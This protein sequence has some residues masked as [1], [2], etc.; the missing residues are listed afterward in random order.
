MGKSRAILS[1]MVSTFLVSC[2]L[3]GAGG[4]DAFKSDSTASESTLLDVHGAGAQ[5]SDPKT[6]DPSDYPEGHGP[7]GDVIRIYNYVR[8]VRSVSTT[9]DSYSIVD[10]GQT[11]FFD[12]RSSIAAPAAG[13][14]FYGQDAGYD[15][16]VPEYRDNGN[17]TVTDLNT[18]LMWQQDPGDKMGWT[19]AESRLESFNLAGYSDWRL[20]SIKELYSLILFSGR[21]ISVDMNDPDFTQIPFIDTDYFVFEYGDTSAGE[22]AI[23]SQYLSATKYV[24]T[25]MN[26]DETVFGVNF[27]DGRIKGYPVVQPQGGEKGFYV[28]FVRGN[29]A[30]GENSFTDNGDGTV[31]DAATGLMWLQ[32]DS[33][34]GMSWGEAL[35]WA[36]EL[37]SAGYSDWRLPDAKELQSLVD[38]SR[39]P[40]TTDSAAIDPLF[41][42]SVITDEGEEDN[43]PF[44]WTSTTHADSRENGG[45]AAYLAFGE[46]LGFMSFGGMGP[47][48]RRPM[49]SPRGSNPPPRN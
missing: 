5:R 18:G 38:Y 2:Q 26:G 42:C 15:G 20:P 14:D 44:Y 27:A 6:G 34:T 12:S 10:T 48:G 35:D 22:R 31:T 45:N 43:Y 40:D 9:A 3:F 1:I 36:E 19:E 7:Q 8:P 17:G 41:S 4:P 23:D 32:D 37:E 49:G 28:L 21:D 47:R 33:G 16:L 46:A 13:D 39:S 25:T 30:Y 24:S 29:T 11:T